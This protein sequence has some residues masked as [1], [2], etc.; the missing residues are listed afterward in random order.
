MRVNGRNPR[1]KRCLLGA[2]TFGLLS[3]CLEKPSVTY[4]VCNSGLVAEKRTVLLFW[5]RIPHRRNEVLG[6]KSCK[7]NCGSKKSFKKCL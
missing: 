7:V 5:A 4:S 2:M 3:Y 1:E 6:W